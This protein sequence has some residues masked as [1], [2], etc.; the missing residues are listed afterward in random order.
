MHIKC[1]CNVLLSEFNIKIMKLLLLV[2]VLF[3][4]LKF[5]FDIRAQKYETNT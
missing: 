4:K 5:I 2:K 1:S 3:T